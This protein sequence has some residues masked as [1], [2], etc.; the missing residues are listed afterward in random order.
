MHWAITEHISHCAFACVA[1]SI[2][3]VLLQFFTLFDICDSFCNNF[4][5]NENLW[6]SACFSAKIERFSNRVNHPPISS[7]G[8]EFSLTFLPPAPPVFCILLGDSPA[9]PS[10]AFLLL[11]AGCVLVEGVSSRSTEVLDDVEEVVAEVEEVVDWSVLLTST[12]GLS[13]SFITFVMDPVS[14]CCGMAVK[15]YSPNNTHST[16]RQ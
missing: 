7:W 16:K 6:S 12:L 3:C 5:F 11:Q 15:G 2:V 1:L 13:S 14:V 9:D 8:N 10:S 4:F